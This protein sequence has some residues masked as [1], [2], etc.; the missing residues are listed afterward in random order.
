MKPM[1]LMDALGELPD[2]FI[3]QKLFYE[4][5]P[6]KRT[7][8]L[9][10]K[11]FL[12]GVSTAACLLLIVGLGVGVWSRQ[13]KIETI[14][15]QETQTTTVT[16]TETKT[17]TTA[18]VTTVTK[19]SEKQTA[20]TT[21]MPETTVTLPE[22]I[23]SYATAVQTSEMTTAEAT[24]EQIVPATAVQTIAVTTAA[25]S[26]SI[27]TILPTVPT[28]VGHYG[29]IPPR[30]TTIPENTTSAT[31][32]N[33]TTVMTTSVK[34]SEPIETTT[35]PLSSYPTI[36]TSVSTTALTEPFELPDLQG[37][38]I[39]RLEESNKLNVEYKSPVTP[40]PDDFTLY[41]L[42]LEEYRSVN[43]NQPIMNGSRVYI[44]KFET[45]NRSKSNEVVQ[46]ERSSWQFQCFENDELIEMEIQGNPAVLVRN[47]D[48]R[49]LYWD[50]GYY[51]FKMLKVNGNEEEMLKI[52]EHLVKSDI[53]LE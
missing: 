16:Q 28:Y 52:A 31:Q 49:G 30:E 14:P 25:Q 35:E 29:T 36:D 48:S 33:T 44:Y 37:F 7:A 15:P 21:K 23:A 13:R 24:S 47:G 3:A 17:E 8:F 4:P 53:I 38:S 10:S 1:D 26:V 43:V 9:V 34:A 11:P 19:A 42:Q 20:P 39:T 50:D 45:K 2:D 32:L 22:V 46:S 6:C 51:S 18:Q 41:E 12:A 5:V 40:S 27:T